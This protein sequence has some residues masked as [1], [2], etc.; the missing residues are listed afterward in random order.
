MKFLVAVDGSQEAADALAYATDV[1]DAMDGTITAV[2][3]VDPEVYDTGGDEPTSRA[4]TDRRLLIRSI[5]EAEERGLR[6]LDEAAGLADELG[7]DIETRLLYGEPVKAITG[8]ADDADFDAI[9]VGHR[10][11]SE[12][13]DL[14]L[15]STAKTI[16]ERSTVPVTVTR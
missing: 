12:R 10:G 16:V 9:F 15:G 4:E 13:T 2:H 14:M 11:R 6:I 5:E 1:A 7:R 3:A 8:Y